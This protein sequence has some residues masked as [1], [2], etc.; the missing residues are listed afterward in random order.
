MEYACRAVG[1]LN[2][3]SEASVGVMFVALLAWVPYSWLSKCSKRGKRMQY[4]RCAVGL[5]WCHF[6]KK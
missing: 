3:A 4:V 5:L 2:A 6:F 1:I